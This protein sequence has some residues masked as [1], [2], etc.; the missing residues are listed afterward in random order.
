MT[1][2]DLIFVAV[3]FATLGLVVAAAT[4]A[5][6]GKGRQAVRTLRG[7]GI[8]L[9]GYM[10]VVAIV[11]LT[12]PQQVVR[13]N[14]PQCFDDWCISVAHVEQ[15]TLG[16]E[17][18]YAVTLRLSSRA[19]RRPQRESAVSVYVLDE[20]G[21]RYDP[22]DA[23]GAVP[24]DVLLEPGESRSTTRIFTLPTDARRPGLVV[25]HGWFPGLFIVG[26]GQSLFH[27]PIVVPLE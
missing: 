26:D 27:K 19:L 24:L 20:R 14:Q 16:A 8:F 21:R 6:R 5:I 3:F 4:S 1:L 11:S 10:V 7:L 25:A 9:A 18:S 12:S 22:A 23:P 13:L 15:T 17:V 2:Y